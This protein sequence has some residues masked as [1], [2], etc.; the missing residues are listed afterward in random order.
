MDSTTGDA[1]GIVT[2]YRLRYTPRSMYLAHFQ[3]AVLTVPQT[4]YSVFPAPRCTSPSL[5][6]RFR[7]YPPHDVPWPP[8]HPRTLHPYPHVRQ[9]PPPSAVQLRTIMYEQNSPRSP[10]S[11]TIFKQPRCPLCTRRPFSWP[12]TPALALDLR[13]EELFAD[14]LVVFSF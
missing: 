3:Y 7:V 6:Q 1:V 5:P 10:C 8:R 4:R 13:T 2:S 14:A 11:A 12:S 9:Y